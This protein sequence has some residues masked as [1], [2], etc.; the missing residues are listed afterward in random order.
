MKI[1]I[2]TKPYKHQLEDLKKTLHRPV[3][4][5]YWEQGLGKSKVIIDLACN[6]YIQYR[7]QAVLIIAPNNVHR[8][9]VDQEIPVHAS[10]DF[11]AIA[12]DGSKTTKKYKKELQ[13]AFSKP[14]LVFFT[15]NYEAL[16][17]KRGYAIAEYFIN[18]F[19][20]LF[21]LDESHRIKNQ[22]AK[23]T[24]KLLKLAINPNVIYKRILTGTPIT[25]NPLDLY[26]QFAFLDKDI[27]WF[28]SFHSFKHHYAEVE[29]IRTYKKTAKH[30]NGWIFEQIKSFKNMDELK[31]KIN[32]YMTRKTKDECL[33]L[34]DKIYQR[35]PVFLT[36]KQKKV[37]D[38][39]EKNLSLEFD[40]NA[41][42]I[43]QEITNL[44]TGIVTCKIPL[45]KILRLRQIISNFVMTDD[46]ETITIDDD[47]NPK[48]D[49]LLNDLEDAFNPFIKYDKNNSRSFNN[50]PKIIIWASFKYEIKLITEKLQ[51]LYGTKI[52]ASY[53][54][55]TKKEDRSI[56]RARF[57]DLDPA[58]P[59]KVHRPSR[60]RILVSNPSSGG[61]GV[62]LTKASINYYF[63]NSY[64]AEH[65]WQ[66]EDRSH[67]I[68]QKNTVIY[69]DI[70]AVDTVDEEVHKVLTEKARI[71]HDIIDTK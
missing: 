17:T 13:T 11:S 15:M 3:Y 46:G 8:N 70:V 26:N 9:W 39:L 65:R 2:K 58:Q 42:E 6:L 48:L 12:W 67:R 66:S 56:I 69:K 61:I 43:R 52:V 50:T 18:R 19:K 14:A 68:G 30:P 60:L 24:K 36:K 34:P 4:A 59:G 33:D 35:I 32:P 29:Q 23:R 64:D 10:I 57:Q 49:A 47:C 38:D 20:C 28:N 16:P 51:D 44:L 63:S 7:I 45:T 62:D 54:G 31:R 37:Y 1:S 22:S 27:L 71:A 55:D 21:V 41:L 25:G 40:S 5:H 53:Y